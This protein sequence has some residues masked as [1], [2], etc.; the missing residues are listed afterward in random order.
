MGVGRQVGTR[1][2]VL[3]PFQDACPTPTVTPCPLPTMSQKQRLETIKHGSP[4]GGGSRQLVTPDG[5]KVGRESC[6][7]RGVRNAIKLEVT[8]SWVPILTVQLTSY[9]FGQAIPSL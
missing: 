3:L 8:Q 1:C 9:E 7:V 2:L 6:G 5:Q 4:G